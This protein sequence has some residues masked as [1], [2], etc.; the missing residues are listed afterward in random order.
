MSGDGFGPMA[1]NLSAHRKDG[2]GAPSKGDARRAIER[3]PVLRCFHGRW[4]PV[5][6][7][8]DPPRISSSGEAAE[9]TQDDPLTC[10]TFFLVLAVE[11]GNFS[12][13]PRRGAIAA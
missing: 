2:R 13:V 1:G 11:D 10:S 8:L 4:E 6:A 3:S 7:S 5:E 9:S 12:A